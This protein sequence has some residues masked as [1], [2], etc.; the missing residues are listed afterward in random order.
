MMVR[1]QYDAFADAPNLPHA[2]IK[3]VHDILAAANN[4]KDPN[5][6]NSRVHVRKAIRAATEAS[7]PADLIVPNL[8]YWR[9]ED[10]GSPAGKNRKMQPLFHVY[11]T[12]QG[13]TFWTEDKVT[14]R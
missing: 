1:D 13:N 11:R 8:Y 2:F 9:T 5:Y 12:I 10:S 3:P 6:T 4:P 14:G 7:P